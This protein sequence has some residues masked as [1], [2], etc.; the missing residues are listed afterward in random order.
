VASGFSHAVAALSIGAFFYR[1]G[2][3]KRVW[4]V[5]A[6]CSVIPDLDVIGFRFGIRYGDFWGHRG[7][8]HSL[9][10]SAFLASVVVIVGFRGGRPTLSRFALWM[11]FFLATASHGLLDAMTDGGLGVAFFSPFDNQRYFLPWRPIRVSPI[12]AGRF[13]THRGLEVLQSELLWIWVPAALLALSVWLIRRR[14]A[15]T[16]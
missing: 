4:V 15:P 5:G 10:F 9:L 12:G 11:Y 16:T 13:F 1:A 8:T 7:F 14:A 6:L 3:P 2:T